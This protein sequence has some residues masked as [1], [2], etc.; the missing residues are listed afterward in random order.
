MRGWGDTHQIIRFI[1]ILAPSLHPPMRILIP[2]V[3]TRG[4]AARK[5]RRENFSLLRGEKR[6]G[7]G[8]EEVWIVAEAGGRRGDEHL[9]RRAGRRK[10][11]RRV[12]MEIK[13]TGKT[14]PPRYGASTHPNGMASAPARLSPRLVEIILV[15]II[16]P[17][18]CT[19]PPPPAVSPGMGQLGGRSTSHSGDFCSPLPGF[20]QLRCWQS[21]R[22]L[23]Y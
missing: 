22:V 4:R 12:R 3:P 9:P 5:Y 19:L 23:P 11:N 2:S 20:S 18:P 10:K 14:R 15:W 8:G 13:G 6:E 1:K 7:K 16:A 17:F 21:R